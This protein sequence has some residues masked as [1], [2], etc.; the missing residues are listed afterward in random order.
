MFPT[1]Q[2]IILGVPE[3]HRCSRCRFV[4]GLS[5]KE[6]PALQGRCK[7]KSVDKPGSNTFLGVELSFWFI[8]RCIGAKFA[9]FY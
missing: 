3:H 5:S 6:L 1:M 2:L 4:H 9:P 8:A 7:D